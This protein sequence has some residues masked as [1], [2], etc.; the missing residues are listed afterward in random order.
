MRYQ[1]F[2]EEAELRRTKRCVTRRDA[3]NYYRGRA[4]CLLIHEV[5]SWAIEVISWGIEVITH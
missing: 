1:R 2:R 4:G 3:P 5:I